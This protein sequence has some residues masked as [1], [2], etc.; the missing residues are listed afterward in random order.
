V[1]VVTPNET[2]ITGGLRR[3]ERVES[4]WTWKEIGSSWPIVVGKAGLASGAGLHGSSVQGL[5]VKKEGD[6]KSP[7]GVFTLR[8]AFGFGE[9][10]AGLRIPYV[11]LSDAHECVDDPS[12]VQYNRIVD[13]SRT[14]SPDWKSSEKMR[15]IEPYVYGVVVDHNSEPARPGAGSCIFL[16]AWS[17]A[18]NPTV[19]CT[20]MP[21]ERIRELVGWLDPEAGPV[22]VQLT[23]D[24]YQALREPWKLPR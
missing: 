7:A 3:F 17:A 15:Q 18:E 4:G 19:G 13:R 20:A 1:L 10:E 23:Q 6:G 16:H 14:P 12:S 2:A 24:A 8:S 9:A 21:V 22:L 5:P 11:R